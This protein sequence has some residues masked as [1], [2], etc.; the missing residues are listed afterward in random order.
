M[1]TFLYVAAKQGFVVEDY[2]DDAVG[3]MS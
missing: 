3:E 1:L 2:A